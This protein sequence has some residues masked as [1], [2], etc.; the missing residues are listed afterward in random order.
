MPIYF[1]VS[2]I[3]DVGIHLF[4]KE[5]TNMARNANKVLKSFSAW[6]GKQ[7]PTAKYNYT[8]NFDCPLGLFFQ[9]KGY[10]R[11]NSSKM[12]IGGASFDLKGI[13]YIIPEKIREALRQ[14]GT[15]GAL[16]VA[17]SD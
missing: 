5:V 16:Y 14:S 1:V 9:S 6:V 11:G 12:I 8:S 2:V 10:E 17:L 15:Y 4:K 7:D 13:E 3:F